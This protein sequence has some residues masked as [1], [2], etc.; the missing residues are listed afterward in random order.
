MYQLANTLRTASEIKNAFI[1]VKNRKE[2]FENCL[3]VLVLQ[4]VEKT[5]KGKF[6]NRK[7]YKNMSRTK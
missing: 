6:M 3:S 5:I 1:I 2:K 7:V 4:M